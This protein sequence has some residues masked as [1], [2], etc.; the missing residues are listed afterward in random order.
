MGLV[1]KVC[2]SDFIIVTKFLMNET[3]HISKVVKL[4]FKN[5]LRGQKHLARRDKHGTRLA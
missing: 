2:H 4:T 5:E 1:L 3:T